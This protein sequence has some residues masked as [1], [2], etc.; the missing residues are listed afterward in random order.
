MGDATAAVD[1]CDLHRADAACAV[2][3]DVTWAT[4]VEA[5]PDGSVLVLDRVGPRD[6]LEVS[7]WRCGHR[8]AFEIRGNDPTDPAT[9]LACTDQRASVQ[10]AL[11][12]AVGHDLVA[13]AATDTGALARLF[14]VDDRGDQ[15]FEFVLDETGADLVSSYHPLRL[16]SGKALISDGSTVSYDLADRWYPIPTLPVRRYATEAVIVLAPGDGT[17]RGFDAGAPG[18]VWHRLVFDA[19]IPPGT[20]VSVDTRAADD[21]V[22]LQRQRW[23]TEPDPYLR[24]G[25]SEIPYHEYRPGACVGQGSWEL[26]LQHAVGRYLQVRLTLRGDGRRTP[27]LW[28]AR[29]H[30]PRFSY[31]EHYLPD[32]YRGDRESAWFLD[33]YLANAEGLYTALEGRIT[34]IRR[35]VDPKT[36]DTEFLPWLAAW[37]GAV[38]E[39]DWEPERQRLLV[40]YAARMFTRRGTPRGLIEAIR[41][42]TDPCPT[43]AIFDPDPRVDRFDVRVVEAF[44]TRSVP[45]TALGDP[46]DLAGPRYTAPEARWRLTEGGSALQ[47]RWRAFLADRYDTGGGDLSTAVAAAWGRRWPRSAHRPPSRCSPR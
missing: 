12:G 7:R 9:T 14:I 24:G 28:A 45:G 4:A 32:I 3:L 39:P 2:A 18:T 10:Q 31:L 15:A 33:R 16:F 13:V 1:R 44:R 34:A 40:R 43:E 19:A 35:L 42:A 22:V 27:R 36:I 23:L 11:G 26:L 5:L 20:T 41:L 46:T 38:V 8:T 29:L 30:Y 21:L 17:H 37:V 25:G 6:R 47:R